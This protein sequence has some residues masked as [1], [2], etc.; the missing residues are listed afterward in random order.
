MN[1]CRYVGLL[2]L[3][4]SHAFFAQ[5]TPEL[6]FDV[7]TLDCSGTAPVCPYHLEHLDVP[8]T[9]G[10]YIAMGSDAHRLELATNGNALAIY[11]NTFN[12]GYSTNSGLQQAAM[13]DSQVTPL[14]TTTGPKPNWIVLNE[15]SSSLWQTDATY[16]LWAADVVHALRIAYGYNVILYS[17]F[18]NPGANNSD[19]QNVS[20]DAYIGIENY[21]SG[22]EVQANGLSVS[23]CQGQYQSSINSYTGRGVPRARL[24]LGEHFA[25]TL[26]GTSYGRSGI[27]SNDW[28]ITIVVRDQAAVN[29]GFSGFLSYAWGGND[30]GVSTNE[31][32]H[33]EDTYAT[34]RLPVNNGLTAPF[35]V[36]Q[37]NGQTLPEGSDVAFTVFKAGNAPT[38]YQWRFNG[39]NIPGETGSSLNLTSVQVTNAGN[40]SVAMTN[41][42]GFVISS[43]AFLSVRVP[44]PWAFEPF[45][46]AAT[47]YTPGT[48]LVGQTNASGKFWLQAGP[49]GVQ[50]TIQAGSLATAGLPGPTG[51]SV[52][53]G[54]NGMSA[55][56]V[57]GTNITS[58]T[59]YYSFLFRLTDIS[60]LNSSGVFWAG[61]NN[62]A[63]TQT[64]TPTSVGTR[65]LTRSAAG[66]FNIGLD[67]S[68]GSPG[69]F[70][71]SPAVFTTNDTIFVVGSY[72]FVPITTN[73]DI[74]QLW[75]DPAPSTFGLALAPPPT[76]TSVATNDIPSAVIAS[77]VLFNRNANEPAGIIADEIRVGPSWASVT[78]PAEAPVVPTLNISGTVGA[79]VL[80]WGTN[81]PGFVLESSPTLLPASWMQSAL[82]VY[83]AGDQFAVT[84]LNGIDLSFY[85]LRGPQ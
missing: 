25:Q 81:A 83:L 61:F 63:V 11:Y 15:I 2:V 65:L 22:A 50:P 4:C 39:T 8:T 58:G 27:S 30:M 82:P 28:D 5:A 57:L 85:R 33:F 48:N 3:S 43:N 17:P 20:A 69:A 74:C 41:A 72:T 12:D 19:W 42:V 51:N 31:Q 47:S 14:F 21:L 13:I 76:L 64:T 46:P 26:S 66:G 67:K 36:V 9:N 35:I 80:T 29:V 10:Y 52:K 55:R 24:M 37:P 32:L 1:S 53:F 7:L 23:Y 71:F 68:S 49:T 70:V 60:T 62:S 34:N 38:T 77:L 16:R 6:R 40:Y 54:G 56:L 59:W 18:P 75:I 84:N 73:D 44:D 78:P 45:A 79:T